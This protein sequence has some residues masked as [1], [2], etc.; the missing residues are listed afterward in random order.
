MAASLVPMATPSATATATAVPSVDATPGSWTLVK[1]LPRFEAW[2]AVG[3]AGTVLAV[4]CEVS[5]GDHECDRAAIRM[6]DGGEWRGAQLDGET[7]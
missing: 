4:G 1:N 6:S 5:K 7:A 2:D 3:V